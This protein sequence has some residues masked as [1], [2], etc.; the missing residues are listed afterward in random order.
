MT[1]T[2]W[3]FGDSFCNHYTEK[4]SKMDIVQWPW[5]V[6][7]TMYTDVKNFGIGG[8]SNY[9]ILQSILTNLP[10]IKPSD[11]IVIG[12]TDCTRVHEVIDSNEVKAY[13]AEK[14]I[15]EDNPHFAGHW[16]PRP[17]REPMDSF[18]LDE[19]LP[20]AQVYTKWWDEAF[21]GLKSHLKQNG[22]KVILF[23]MDM[24]PKFESIHD[25]TKGKIMDLHWSKKG[26]EDFS[27]WITK[28]FD[29]VNKKLI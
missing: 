1:H 11:Y 5:L 20:H 10:N 22:Y 26:H 19:L 25:S 24:W 14:K 21:D 3:V 7:N 29:I 12:T 15:L 23:G 9:C 6:S 8:N 13:S 16:K 28:D 27:K 2:L 18:V 4:T 17:S